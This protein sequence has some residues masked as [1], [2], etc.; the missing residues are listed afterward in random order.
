MNESPNGL[1]NMSMKPAKSNI[2]G[3]TDRARNAYVDQGRPKDVLA[4]IREGLAQ[5]RRG[6][7]RPAE[8]VLDELERKGLNP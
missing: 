3:K 2:G 5:P 1:K 8:E 7:S 6:E 4:A